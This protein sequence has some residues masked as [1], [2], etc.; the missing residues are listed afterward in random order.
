[1]ARIQQAKADKA[2][3]YAKKA[4]YDRTFNQLSAMSKRDL[5]DIGIRSS[6]IECIAAQA[7]EMR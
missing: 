4:V 5:A 2:E 6:D 1:M 7:V 3:F